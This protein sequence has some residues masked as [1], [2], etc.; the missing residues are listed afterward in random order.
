MIP[1]LPGALLDMLDAP[2]PL[3]AGITA[4]QYEILIDEEI[5]EEEEMFQKVWIHISNKG[6]IRIEN[7]KSQLDQGIAQR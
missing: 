7:M 4:L 1:I 6:T 2:V 3:I 5:I